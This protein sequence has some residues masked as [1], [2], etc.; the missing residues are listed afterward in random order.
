MRIPRYIASVLFLIPFFFL[1][2]EKSPYDKYGV[3]GAPVHTD[4]KLA[5][6]SP[7]QVYK[8]DVSYQAIDPKVWAKFSKFSNLQVLHISSNGVNTWPPDFESL[9][10][11]VY[12]ST[13]NNEFQKLPE[14]KSF[15]NLMYFEMFATKIDSIPQS[16]NYLQR[17]KTFKFSSTED[18]LKLP[19][20]M[21]FMKSLQELVIESVIL[22]SMPRTLFRIPSVKLISLVNC[23]VQA[24]PEM[25]DKIPLLEVLI[26][27]QNKLNTIPWDIYRLDKLVLLS[28]KNNNLKSLPPTICHLKNL[29]RLDLRGNSFP[30]EEQEIIKALLPGC[31]VLF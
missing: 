20:T 6:K 10:N 21:R 29:T 17:L 19:R 11:L 1:A 28:L 12:L 22:D 27:D 4:L 26:L 16:I 2:Q 31:K 14:L 25:L 9:R 7:E 3:Y 13:I 24:L 15:S 30:P 23:R 18:T 5:L 8:I